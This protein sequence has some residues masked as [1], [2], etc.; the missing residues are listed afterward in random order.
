MPKVTK[1]NKFTLLNLIN[2]NDYNFL[3]AV[4]FNASIV[5][6]PPSS[7]VLAC[8]SLDSLHVAAAAAMVVMMQWTSNQQ[9]RRWMLEQCFA[10]ERIMSPHIH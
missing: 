5:V 8:H 7:A 3:A 1:L 6:F 10:G 2:L 9:G 4:Q